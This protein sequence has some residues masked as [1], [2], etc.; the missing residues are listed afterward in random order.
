MFAI[1][2][3]RRLWRKVLS[4]IH[5]RYLVSIK[6]PGILQKILSISIILSKTKYALTKQN[7]IEVNLIQIVLS[8]FRQ[9][10]KKLQVH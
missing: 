1:L 8:T 9:G 3:A 2:P 4:V 6:L 10:I 5:E 7:E